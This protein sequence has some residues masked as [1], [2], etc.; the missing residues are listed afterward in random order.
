L[1]FNTYKVFLT[2]K[3][4]HSNET[5]EDEICSKTVEQK[6]NNDKVQCSKSIEVKQTQT[7]NNSQ[8]ILRSRNL[9]INANNE[10]ESDTNENNTQINNINTKEMVTNTQINSNEIVTDIE[11]VTNNETV[12]NRTIDTIEIVKNVDI[13]EVIPEINKIV[14]NIN[15]NESING[16]TMDVNEIDNNRDTIEMDT[17]EMVIDE[18]EITFIMAPCLKTIKEGVN[19]LNTDK[20]VTD[21]NPKKFITNKITNYFKPIIANQG[22]IKITPN[23]I[24]SNTNN[25]NKLQLLPTVIN[26]NESIIELNPSSMTDKN[27]ILNCTTNRIELYPK[28]IVTNTNNLITNEIELNPSSMVTNTNNL[29]TNEMELNPSSMVTNTNNL[30]TNEIELN[31]SSMVTNTNNLITNEIE[32]NPSSMVTNTNNLIINEIATKTNTKKRSSTNVMATNMSKKCKKVTHKVN[33]T[34]EPDTNITINYIKEIIVKDDIDSNSINDIKNITKFDYSDENNTDISIIDSRENIENDTD[35]IYYDKRETDIFPCNLCNA[36]FKTSF[37]IN[38]HEK[39]NH[40]IENKFECV[41]CKDILENKQEMDDH[42]LN[43]HETVK[44]P[45]CNECEQLDEY[46]NELET[47]QRMNLKSESNELNNIKNKLSCFLCQRNFLFKEG[48]IAHLKR[49]DNALRKKEEYKNKLMR[50]SLTHRKYQCK[51]CSKLFDNNLKNTDEDN[52]KYGENILGL[53]QCSECFKNESMIKLQKNNNSNN[54]SNNNN[55]LVIPNKNK[56]YK[57]NICQIE[58]RCNLTLNKHNQK[59]H[60]N[61]KNENS[62][63]SDETV[64]NTNISINKLESHLKNKCTMCTK[65]FLYNLTLNK[66][67]QTCHIS[68]KTKKSSSNDKVTST[69]IK[70]E[71]DKG[72]Y[73]NICSSF[74]INIDILKKHSNEQHNL[75]NKCKVCFKL[76]K[77]NNELKNHYL[78]I[79]KNYYPYAC[80]LCKDSEVFKYYDSYLCHRKA[81]HNK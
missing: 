4:T 53:F 40:A 68:K 35:I 74:F 2:H 3:E 72:V 28:N 31:P 15:S 80:K 16:L 30:I 75:K 34:N 69:N 12:T 25:H 23:K 21:K 27:L 22:V 55:N 77:T 42:I 45:N 20:M 26:T 49:H 63:S 43:Q 33:N 18:N 29:I 57:C 11:L 17:H 79:H 70:L 36:K 52:W 50:H 54:N 7:T 9:R 38:N 61:S 44:Y 39:L 6:E 64:K 14:K 47:K 58:Y 67:I 78:L 56:Y 60:N 66:H 48:L 71:S 10:V 46:I 59:Y 51:Y 32:I 73:C 5:E 1:K 8:I 81:F 19:K 65:K 24:D 62:I 41:L 37:E 76:F 13:I